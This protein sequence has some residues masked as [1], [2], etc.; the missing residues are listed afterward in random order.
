MRRALGLVVVLA[1]MIWV[2]T[3]WLVPRL[4]RDALVM[5]GALW[6]GLTIAFEF[7]FGHFVDGA[8]WSV[9]IMNYDITA[10]RLWILVPVTMAI[11]PLL[12][13]ILRRRGPPLFRL[14]ALFLRSR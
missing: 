14:P 12:A 4:Q 9:L 13:G 3:P 2:A 8:P 1:G 6:F 5:L 10:G 7:L 11:G